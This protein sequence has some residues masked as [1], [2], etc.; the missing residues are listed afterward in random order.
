MQLRG[1][2]QGEGALQRV[3]VGDKRTRFR[4]S[5]MGFQ[6]GGLHLNTVLCDNHY[7]TNAM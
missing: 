1:D 4:A 5:C 3:V 2:A 7:V 6:H